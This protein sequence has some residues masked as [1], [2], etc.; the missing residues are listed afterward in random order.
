[1]ISPAVST[2][3]PDT[4]AHLASIAASVPR[5]S[6][7]QLDE[8]DDASKVLRV[9]PWYPQKRSPPPPAVENLRLETPSPTLCTPTLTETIGEG[10]GRASVAAVLPHSCGF[11]EGPLEVEETPR[12]TTVEVAGSK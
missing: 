3:L 4:L 10:I 9:L 7:P 1:M 2:S 11:W 5:L 8:G 12:P 6:R